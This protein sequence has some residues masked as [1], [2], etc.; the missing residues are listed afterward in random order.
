MFALN[1]VTNE[2][3]IAAAKPKKAWAMPCV[4][5]PV[6]FMLVEVFAFSFL[7]AE[8]DAWWPLTFGALW[9]VLL[10]GLIRALPRKATRIVFGIVY[11]LAVGYAAVQ[12]GY[13][14]LFREVKVI[15]QFPRLCK[16]FRERLPE[17]LGSQVG[18]CCVADGSMLGTL[19]CLK[20]T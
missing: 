16:A 6:A 1:K 11:A 20:W 2:K 18:C 19:Y 9:T 15:C 13:Y 8:G 4:L 5:V 14:I 7:S 3:D 10:T 12:T 17:I